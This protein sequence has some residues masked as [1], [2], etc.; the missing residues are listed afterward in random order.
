MMYRAFL[1]H[2]STDKE[3]VRAVAKELGRQY[4]LFDEQV[5]EDSEQFK[6]AIETMLDESAVF[7]L[8]VGED[9]LKRIWVKF[10][11]DEAWYRKLEARISKAIVFLLTPSIQ[12]SEL[13]KWRV[14]ATSLAASAPAPLA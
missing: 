2:S 9:T 7:V 5:F 1:S 3:F 6:T 8:F 12:F 4:C 10:E 13:P 14:S 11:I